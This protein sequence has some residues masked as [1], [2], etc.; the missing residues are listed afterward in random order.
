MGLHYCITCNEFVSRIR[1]EEIEPATRG[2]FLGSWRVRAQ[3]A[4]CTEWPKSQLPPD[5]FQP[6]QLQT[7][8][9]LVWGLEDPAS[10]PAEGREE[11]KTYLPNAIQLLVP[12]AAHT[13]ENDCTRAIRHQLFRTGTTGGLDTSCVGKLKLLPFKLSEAMHE[14]QTLWK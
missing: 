10:A 13:P 9:V 4:A 11:A 7:P 1:P 14:R 3:M 12:G 5:F 6:F 2:L 8:A